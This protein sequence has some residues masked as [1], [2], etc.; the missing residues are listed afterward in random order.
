MTSEKPDYIVEIDELRNKH[1]P[2][3]PE[4]VE[5]TISANKAGSRRYICV[6][7]ECCRVYIRI[8]RDRS[9]S[10]YAGRCPRCLRQ[11]RVRIGQGGTDTRFFVAK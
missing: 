2:D 3:H 7:F 5:A 8:Y 9:G 1:S 10:A 6:L 11:V 4:C